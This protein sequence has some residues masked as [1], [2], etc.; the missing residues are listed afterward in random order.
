MHHTRQP[1]APT[2]LPRHAARRRAATI[3]TI[4]TNEVK[5][6]APIASHSRIDRRGVNQITARELTA[7]KLQSTSWRK[8]T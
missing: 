5:M 3:A 1:P 7:S 2:H 6:R 4:S 8:C